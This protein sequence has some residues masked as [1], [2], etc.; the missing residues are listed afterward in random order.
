MNGLSVCVTYLANIWGERLRNERQRALK[1]TVE[2]DNG[3]GGSDKL[4]TL[5][6]VEGSSGVRALKT[7][8]T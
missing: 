4:C 6:G 1:K 3:F 2:C 5:V 8:L 7:V